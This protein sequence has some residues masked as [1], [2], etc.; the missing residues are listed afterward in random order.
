MQKLRRDAKREHRDP[1]DR[2]HLRRV[3]GDEVRDL[4]ADRRRSAHLRCL[5]QERDEK[6]PQDERPLLR[7]VVCDERSDLR[8]VGRKDQ[9]L[10]SLRADRD[11][12]DRQARAQLGRVVRRRGF[13]G[14]LYERRNAEA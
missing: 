14:H 12:A 9:D 8:R 13:C 1:R 5:R 4:Q 7:R 3:D 10:R 6:H 2:A 11:E